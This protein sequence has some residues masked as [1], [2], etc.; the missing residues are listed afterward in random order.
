MKH[1]PILSSLPSS[2]ASR[3]TLVD[4][5]RGFALLGL[6]LVHCIEYFELYWKDPVPSKVHDVVFFLFAGKAYALFALLFGWSFHAIMENQARKGVDFGTRFLWR[7]VLLLALGF[8][9]GLLYAGDILQVLAVLG[10]TLVVIN[11]LPE[12]WVVAFALFFLLNVPM[13]LWVLAILLP[14]VD[15]RPPLHW[16]LGAQNAEVWA[17][18]NFWDVV[19]VNLWSGMLSKW[20]FYWASGRIFQMIGL[21]LA[22][23]L[24]GRSGFFAQPSTFKKG[25]LGLIVSLLIGG[26]VWFLQQHRVPPPWPLFQEHSLAR[27]YFGNWLDGLFSLCILTLWLYLLIGLWGTKIGKRALEGLVPAGQMSLTIYVMQ[28]IVCV[29]LFYRFGAD[30]YSFIGQAWSLLFGVFF[31][32][33]QGVMA[34]WWMKRFYYGPLEW[35]WRAATYGTTHIL[36]IRRPTKE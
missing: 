17:N 36:F 32:A 20:D 18:G 16:A 12:K 26:T 23:T 7:L 15:E 11:R 27:Y 10:F 4:S 19:K 14:I 1:T 22:G 8:L 33:L 25:R 29:P 28:S 35:C 24:L 9:H 30:L 34:H 31:F 5:L 6:F 13:L 21:F 2:V 3:L